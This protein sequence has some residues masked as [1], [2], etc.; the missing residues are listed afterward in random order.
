MEPSLNSFEHLVDLSGSAG[1]YFHSCR[2]VSL[3]G[4]SDSSKVYIPPK[5]FSRLSITIISFPALQVLHFLPQDV[6]TET[7]GEP[8]AKG[9]Q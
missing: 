6:S 1:Y 8:E 9:S 3:P 4:K 2:I 7:A 5:S